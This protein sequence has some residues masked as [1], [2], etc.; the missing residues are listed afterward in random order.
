MSSSSSGSPSMS[1]EGC[2][3]ESVGTP[4]EV[5]MRVHEHVK[6]RTFFILWL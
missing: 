3:C 5:D 1:S 6:K 4:N 2:L